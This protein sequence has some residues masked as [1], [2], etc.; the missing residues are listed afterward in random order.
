MNEIRPGSD[1]QLEHTQVRY[2]G[3][4]RAGWYIRTS[5][6]AAGG[7][8]RSAAAGPFELDDLER[9]LAAIDGRGDDPEEPHGE[10]PVREQL[11]E[12]GLVARIETAAVDVAEGMRRR[13]PGDNVPTATRKKAIAEL[14]TACNVYANWCEH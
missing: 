9:E 3:I 13:T 4:G 8:T 11:V 7:A 14:T 12:E 6:P 5:I 1:P 10:S 2:H